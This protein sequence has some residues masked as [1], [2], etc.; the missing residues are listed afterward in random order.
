MKLRVVGNEGEPAAA[1]AALLE[2]RSVT[3]VLRLLKHKSM[4]ITT[5][6]LHVT[7]EGEEETV[8]ALGRRYGRISTGV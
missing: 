4:A 2:G 6:Y 7:D 1:Q 5:I 8:G 3:N